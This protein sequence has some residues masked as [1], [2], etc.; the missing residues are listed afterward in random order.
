MTFIR[1]L[2][3][4]LRAYK[5]V[6]GFSPDSTDYNDDLLDSRINK[7]QFLGNLFSPRDAVDIIREEIFLSPNNII[8]LAGPRGSG[9][10][11]IGLK[12]KEILVSR[13]AF[14]NYVIPIDVRRDDAINNITLGQEPFEFFKLK[15]L[16]NLR[17]QFIPNPWD[18]D[19]N[20]EINLVNFIIDENVTQNKPKELFKDFVIEVG[21][22]KNLHYKYYWSKKGEEEIPSLKKWLI[23]KFIE[24]DIQELMRKIKEKLN[25]IHLA[26]A[27]KAIFDYNRIILWIDNI[28]KLDNNQQIELLDAITEVKRA[29]TDNIALVVAVREENIYRIEH[30]ENFAP[31][32]PTTIYWENP[33]AFENAQSY[34]ALN[35]PVVKEDVL[36]DIIEKRLNFTKKFQS[37]L[38]D[39]LKKEVL[40]LN[41][42][43]YS[44]STNSEL[45]KDCKNI[46]QEAISE[47][48]EILNSLGNKITEQE[49]SQIK[50]LSDKA[51]HT[52]ISEKAYFITN[53]SLR[54]LLPLHRDFLLFLI[55]GQNSNIE[56]IEANKY[57]EWFLRTQ[58]LYF[59]TLHPRN[60]AFLP[61]D[62]VN[63]CKNKNQ[64][65]IITCFLP[66]LVLTTIWNYCI[67]TIRE[68]DS[69]I[70]LPSVKEIIN[71]LNKLEY[72]T[73]DIKRTIFKLSYVPGGKSNFI[74]IQTSKE[75][76]SPIDVNFESKIKINYKGKVTLNSLSISFGYFYALV[77]NKDGFDGKHLNPT[78]TVSQ[79][80][81]ILSTIKEMANSHLKS[82]IHIRDNV[83]KKNNDWMTKYYK[84]YGIPFHKSFSRNYDRIG[85]RIIDNSN[86]KHSLYVEAILNSF[87][88]YFANHNSIKTRLD[89]IYNQYATT[90]NKIEKFEIDNISDIKIN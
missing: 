15:I 75:I 84:T 58:F 5:T 61:Y 24:D 79:G 21:D 31:P 35:M 85:K 55:K 1:N 44:D 60:S 73:E 12:T 87:I 64:T 66:H 63:H 20:P 67:T 23:E 52:F 28:D 86:Y 4:F 13:I 16:N 39:N 51:L 78:R 46:D 72:D 76:K 54:Q 7:D 69:T 18:M 32:R 30:F 9:K 37:T 81:L 36:K 47:L 2:K 59:L 68:S 74:T 14:K 57:P 29:V 40:D 53:N 62:I 41:Q 50:L 25:I 3:G 82:L 8:C 11:S 10:T 83:Y 45:D 56:I 42:N 90:L 49:Y 43:N 88:P 65:K 89:G 38:I 27:L 26:F 48:N 6:A 77:K 33:N 34:D 17:E 70:S 19:N 71:L 80:S 22:A